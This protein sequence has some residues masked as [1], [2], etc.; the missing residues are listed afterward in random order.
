MLSLSTWLAGAIL[1]GGLLAVAWVDARTFRLP[2]ALTLPLGVAGLAWGVWSGMAWASLAGVALGYGVFVAV[3]IAYQYLRGR[4]GLGR[5]DAKLLAAGGAWVG[6]SG[7]PLVVLVASGAGLVAV[8]AL[9]GR[10]ERGGPEASGRIPFGPFL[11][12]GA[13]FAVIGDPWLWG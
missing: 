2:D 3:E 8:A 4:D 5:G 7:L 13:V 10:L 11:A 6:W 1:L 12:A 9:R